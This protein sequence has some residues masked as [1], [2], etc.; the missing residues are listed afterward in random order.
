MISH[1]IFDNSRIFHSW[2]FQPKT[3]GH[4]FAWNREAFSH[5]SESKA[6]YLDDE[7]FLLPS[8][9]HLMKPTHLIPPPKKEYIKTKRSFFL[10]AAQQEWI[11]FLC[12]E[13]N[14]KVCMLSANWWC[15]QIPWIA[16]Q[17]PL[18][19]IR[20]EDKRSE[21]QG[22]FGCFAR[23]DGH[24]YCSSLYLQRSASLE[25]VEKKVWWPVVAKWW[26][27][28]VIY[29]RFFTRHQ[30]PKSHLETVIPA[31][32]SEQFRIQ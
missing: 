28:R 3:V 6:Y 2:F 31:F 30:S 17:E 19:P 24:G 27:P 7:E 10:K 4:S 26:R 20:H 18:S 12:F 21:R 23:G 29:A 15:H 8:C 22:R 16:A 14:K 5:E 25:S 13:N 9:I 1:Q 11:I 32:Q